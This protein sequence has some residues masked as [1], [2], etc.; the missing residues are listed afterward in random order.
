MAEDVFRYLLGLVGSAAAADAIIKSMTAASRPP[1]TILNLRERFSDPEYTVVVQ[2]PVG[3]KGPQPMVV[4]RYGDWIVDPYGTIQNPAA[5]PPGQSCV[6][7]KTST[8]GIQEAINYLANTSQGGKILIRSGTYNASAPITIGFGYWD[9]EGEG[10][11]QVEAPYVLANLSQY[12]PSPSDYQAPLPSNYYFDVPLPPEPFLIMKRMTLKL[13]STVPGDTVSFYVQGLQGY[14]TV[15]PNNGSAPA[16]LLPQVEPGTVVLDKVDIVQFT[17]SAYDILQ[18]AR[19]HNFVI[20]NSKLINYYFWYNFSSAGCLGAG[21]MSLDNAIVED[22]TAIAYC[23]GID[24]GSDNPNGNYIIRNV[25]IVSSSSG[26]GAGQPIEIAPTGPNPVHTNFEIENAVIVAV[27]EA[28]SN[29]FNDGFISLGLW[30]PG[31]VHIKNVVVGQIYSS[32]PLPAVN[33][34]GNQSRGTYKID[35]VQSFPFTFWRGDGTQVTT[36]PV[37]PLLSMSFASYSQSRVRASNLMTILS[38][39]TP[40]LPIININFGGNGLGNCTTEIDVEVENVMVG[41]TGSSP[42]SPYLIQLYQSYP[43]TPGQ[44]CLPPRSKISISAG[45]RRYLLTA[46]LVPALFSSANSNTVNIVQLSGAQNLYGNYYQLYDNS[47]PSTP[48]VPSSG[49]AVMNLNPYPVLV[50]IYGGTVTEV[51][52]TR[53]GTT[54][55]V[56]SNS[57]GASLPGVP[58]YLDPGDSITISYSS[59]PTWVWAPAYD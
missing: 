59:A 34:T 56:F 38:S 29:V 23:G 8:G 21:I 44:V 14:N 48:S 37:S 36:S 31:N 49:S 51:Q 1:Q 7:Q 54:Y 17:T 5:C 18:A 50:Y 19:L 46:S 43:S 24:I 32:N 16:D 6:G 13:S 12:T 53:D 20:R 35:N 28:P 45:R 52:V 15:G 22:V 27:G 41:Y 25:F 2:P 3:P 11:V 30:S 33:L 26:G 42:P 9:I 55:T 40:A 47:T 57:S 39:G 58:V 10:N 4:N